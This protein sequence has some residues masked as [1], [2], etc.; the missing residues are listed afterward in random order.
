MDSYD[1]LIATL[2]GAVVGIGL[3]LLVMWWMRRKRPHLF[4]RPAVKD[5]A[6]VWVLVGLA[7]AL[8]AFVVGT[9]YF[10]LWLFYGIAAASI[11]YGIVVTVRTWKDPKETKK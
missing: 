1:P 7:F 6:L 3:V 8:V 9:T 4:Q 11:G 5:T 10:L 2:S